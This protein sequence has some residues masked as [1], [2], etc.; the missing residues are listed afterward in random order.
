MSSMTFGQKALTVIPP[1]KGSF[2]L[3]HEGECKLRMLQ[4]MKCMNTASSK[5]TD[6]RQQCMDYLDCRM[7]RSL[8]LRED[9]T[10]L[11]FKEDEIK[12]YYTKQGLPIPN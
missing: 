12:E 9:W 10:K 7:D 1:M 3:D 8:M 6:C 2:P 5:T 4:Y 11:G